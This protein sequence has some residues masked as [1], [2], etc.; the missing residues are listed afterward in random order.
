MPGSDDYR[1]AAALKCIGNAIVPQVA[2]VFIRAAL[3]SI[4]GGD[5]T[6]RKAR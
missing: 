6:E 2:A 1:R 5:D 3:A 4:A